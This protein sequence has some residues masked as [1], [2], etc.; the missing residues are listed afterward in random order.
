MVRW[1]VGHAL[2]GDRL[3]KVT[4]YRKGKPGK[5]RGRS[6]HSSRRP[7]LSFVPFSFKSST[8]D[9]TGAEIDVIAAFCWMP[10][11]GGDV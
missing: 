9:N 10:V 1:L 3:D 2:L 5:K 7:V 8:V 4:I 6:W 11:A